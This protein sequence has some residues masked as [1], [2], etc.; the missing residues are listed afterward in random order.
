M[1]SNRLDT[2]FAI[3]PMIRVSFAD[4][5]DW[6]RGALRLRDRG[7]VPRGRSGDAA[8]SKGKLR[9]D[10]RKLKGHGLLQCDRSRYAYRLTPKG[11]Q[12]EG[13]MLRLPPSTRSCHL[14]LKC[15][16]L[17]ENVDCC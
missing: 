17:I 8:D 9:Y 2:I 3:S 10:L 4:A 14:R 13:G 1:S 11:V 12:V 15:R 7:S 16:E 6:F 5:V